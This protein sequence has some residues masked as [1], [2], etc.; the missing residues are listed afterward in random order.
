M[1]PSE[2]APEDATHLR[3]ADQAACGRDHACGL[4]TYFQVSL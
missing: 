4:K 2:T 1:P 3:V